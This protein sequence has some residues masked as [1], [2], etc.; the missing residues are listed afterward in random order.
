MAR[1]F[2]GTTEFL[3]IASALGLTPPFTMAVMFKLN[4]TASTQTLMCVSNGASQDAH[5]MIF[6]SGGVTVGAAS[7]DNGVSSG[8]ALGGAPSAGAFNSGVGVWNAINSRQMV[9]NGSTSAIQSTSV[10]ATSLDEINVGRYSA[11]GGSYANV[12]VQSVA[13]WT[14]A[15]TQPECASLSLGFP[16]RRIRPQSLV[17]SADLVRDVF[18]W[19]KSGAAFATATGTVVDH[20]RIYGR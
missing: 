1:S 15:L 5:Y 17:L 8:E 11:A 12:T 13:A 20:N 2:N 16:P 6:R 4:S 18:D 10:N 3:R 19:S 14:A 9:L 7:N